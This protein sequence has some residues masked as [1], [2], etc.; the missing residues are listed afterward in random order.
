MSLSK[1]LYPPLST[2]S[3]Q[4]DLSRHD[5]KIVNWDVKNQTK[6]SFHGSLM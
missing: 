6:R 4:E 1:T 5:L 2:G 3:S